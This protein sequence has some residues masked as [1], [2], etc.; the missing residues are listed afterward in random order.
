MKLINTNPLG[1]ID[2]PLIGR[3]LEAGEEFEVSDE[4]GIALL[5]QIGNYAESKTTK[6]AKAP[7]TTEESN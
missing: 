1:A 2:L 5:E 7:A 3:S 6:P 4:I